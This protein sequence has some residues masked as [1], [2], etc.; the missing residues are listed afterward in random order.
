MFNKPKEMIPT[1]CTGRPWTNEM[2]EARE[3]AKLAWINSAHRKALVESIRHGIK[4][5][6]QDVKRSLFYKQEIGE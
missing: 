2:I 5:V 6:H 1:D 3:R 4:I